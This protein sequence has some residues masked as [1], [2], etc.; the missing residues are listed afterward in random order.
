VLLA[1]WRGS[2][3]TQRA[4]AKRKGIAPGTMSWWA[5]RLR[6]EKRAKAALVPVHVIDEGRPVAGAEGFRLE[7]AQGRVVHVPSSFDAAALR[8]LLTVLEADGC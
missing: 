5:S 4:F 6:R 7:L 3:L 1:E 8:R 2:G